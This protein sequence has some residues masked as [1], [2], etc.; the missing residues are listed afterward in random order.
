M[1]EIVL[2]GE[3]IGLLPER[4]LWWPRKKT[5]VTADLHWGKSGHFRK[6]GIA[7]PSATQ[8]K[9][10]IRLA[11]LIHRYGAERLIVA[12]DF[13][14]SKHNQEVEHFSHWRSSHRNLHIDLV[15]GNH[16]ILQRGWYEALGIA[17][18]S[19]ALMEAPFLLSHDAPVDQEHFTIHGH[20]HPGI[21]LHGQGR[22][23]LSLSCFCIDDHRLIL[24]A[25]GSFT[26]RY[27]LDPAD[28]S[29]LYA[30]ADT[31]VLQLK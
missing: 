27:Y 13:F 12:G 11:Q 6:N 28:H 10:E 3:Q 26:G 9:D 1:L 24:P 21:R 7:I 22:Q 17:L 30:I 29:N 23:S 14:H 4:A 8:V 5:I 15:E 25:F 20:I 19:P 18:H 2:R 31:Q 16:D